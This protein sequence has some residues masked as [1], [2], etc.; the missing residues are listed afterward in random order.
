MY[1]LAICTTCYFSGPYGTITDKAGSD[2]RKGTFLAM[3][4]SIAKLDWGGRRAAL[5]IRD[6]SLECDFPALPDIGI[7][8]HVARNAEKVGCP[9]NLTLACNDAA[10]LAPFIIYVDND[11]LFSRRSIIRL[12]DL[13][14]RYPDMEAWGMFN[15]RYHKDVAA[16]DDHVI[17]ATI[18][19]HGVCFPTKKWDYAPIYGPIAYA[20][21]AGLNGPY[22]TLRPSGVQH[23]GGIYGLNGTSDD[24]DEEF[25]LSD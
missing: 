19:E 15:T 7:P 13:M 2:H 24:T 16:Y 11:G 4:E 17:K 8:I 12:F 21:C 6:D 5:F 20:S 14:A 18:C 25:R 3:L 10:H 9:M 23:C 1:D 22:P